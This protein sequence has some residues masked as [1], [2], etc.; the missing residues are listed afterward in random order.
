MTQN[1]LEMLYAYIL[2]QYTRY[3]SDLQYL[4]GRMR[5]SRIDFVDC[6]EMIIAL[7]RF[8]AFCT[9]SHDIRHILHLSKVRLEDVPDP[10][11]GNC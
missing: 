10:R 1:E 5:Y 11:K 3:E 4:Q 9:F 8:H 7:E 2:N 6:L